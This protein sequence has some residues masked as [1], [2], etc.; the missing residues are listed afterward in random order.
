MIFSWRTVHGG[1]RATATPTS[2]G[3]V[4]G[5]CCSP[6]AGFPKESHRHLAATVGVPGSDG[7]VAR[8]GWPA[9]TANRNRNAPPMSRWMSLTKIRRRR[10]WRPFSEQPPSAKSRKSTITTTYTITIKRN[11]CVSRATVSP[12]CRV[13]ARLSLCRHAAPW[14]IWTERARIRSFPAHHDTKYSVTG[15]MITTDSYAE[16]YSSN[17][18][19]IIIYSCDF[20]ATTM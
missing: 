17:A 9:A 2:S 7:T 10:F 3:P 18:T 5:Q 20:V 14:L 16:A 12:M 19:M 15:G 4:D 6:S 11:L 1:G 13:T 8:N